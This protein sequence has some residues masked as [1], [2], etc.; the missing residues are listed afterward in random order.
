[1]VR[2]QKIAQTGSGVD[3]QRS[4]G[5]DGGSV[6][7][8]FREPADFIVI[9]DLSRY[10]ASQG[11]APRENSRLMKWC[12]R[13]VRDKLKELC[14]PFGIPVLEALNSKLPVITSNLS[15]L[16]ETGGNAAIYINP[17]NENELALAMEAVANNTELRTG[18]IEKGIT[19]ALNFTKQRCA[20]AVM[21]VY[22][23]L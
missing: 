15:C 2:D 21:N 8:K 16:P 20:E 5:D 4:P 19:H 14:E 13:A 10:R 12:H 3:L 1:M 22:K 11:R 7:E 9:E 23:T 17:E 6:Y 18:M